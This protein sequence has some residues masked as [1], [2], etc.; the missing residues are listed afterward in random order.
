MG[1]NL[2]GILEKLPYL[3]ELGINT[4]WLSPVNETSAYHGY[5][6]TDFYK[7]DR[8]FGK[9]KDLIALI[10]AAHRLNIR[11]ILDFV[12][13]HCSRKHP[14]FQEALADHKSPYRKWF[15][16]KSQSNKYLCFLDFRELPK[17]RLGNRDA[18]NHII[19]AALYWL[20]KGTD[21]FR[22]DHA[23]GPEHDFWKVFSTEV[24]IRNPEA[25]LIG[26][27]W[28]EGIK[29]SHLKTIRVRNKY[30]RWLYDLKPRQIQQEYAGELDGVLDFY[31]RYLITEY[32]ARKE[33]PADCREILLG[34]M[35]EHYDFFPE[36]YFLPSF[37]DNHDMSRFIYEAGQNKAKL[38]QA[39]EIQFSLPQ[40]PVL[41]YGT[42]TALTHDAPVD[43]SVPYSDLQARKPM[44]WHS[45]DLDMVNFCRDLIARRKRKKPSEYLP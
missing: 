31:F 2:K 43:L 23:I 34:K 32:I 44:P 16:F 14:F 15:Y 37:V 1:G 3:H 17:I 8:H 39:L 20:G 40:P 38:K 28:M 26:E 9:E 11:V 4:L 19:G 35:K 25:V 21:G 45:L 22:L 30:L 12:P 42:E 36:A 6:I 29:F 5:H 7:V 24:K 27:A 13:N 10:E 18:R 33:H 41:Y